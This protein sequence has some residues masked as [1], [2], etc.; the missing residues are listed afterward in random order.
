VQHF[1]FGLYGAMIFEA[2]DAYF[3]SIAS[4]NPDGSVNLNGIPIGAGTDGKKRVA[5]NLDPAVTGRPNPFPGFTKGNPEGIAGGDPHAY[6]VPYDVEA[7]WVVDDRD[8]VWSDFAPDAR[9][10]YPAHGS[11]PG[12][13]DTFFHGIFH[14]FNADYWFVTGVP[15]PAHRVDRGGTGF[16]VIDP[17]GAGLPGG[18]I[19]PELNS[20]ISGTQIAVNARVGQTVLFRVLD[21][22]YNF[23]RVT[24]P[25]P[26][27]VI[28]FD[29][30]AL[31]VPPFGNYNTA[32]VLPARTPILLST[33][34][35]FDCITRF[36]RPFNGFASVDFLD[37]QS[38]T[39]GPGPRLM[40]AQIPITITP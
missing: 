17:V 20:G 25:F 4:T 18:L 19:P 38:S 1:E 33:A 21:A 39:N 40:T 6:T 3:A 22:A 13:N 14:D 12:V 37:T 2:P 29:G 30:R 27:A 31:G 34:R 24:F 10:Y 7:L 16:G 28:A 5:C 36:R 35:R 32:F 9:A 8:S 23:A 11:E 26:V 15:V